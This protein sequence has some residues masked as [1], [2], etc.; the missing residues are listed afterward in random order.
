M[1]KKATL[2]LLSVCFSLISISSFS[3]KCTSTGNGPWIPAPLM[4]SCGHMP[5]CTDSILIR[6]G[7][8]IWLASSIDY[9]APP[10]SCTSPMY[11]TISGTLGFQTGKKLSLPAGSIIIV[12]AGGKISPGAGGGSS[13]LIDIG[14]VDVWTAG[15]GTA[16]GP[17]TISSSSPLPIELISFTIHNDGTNVVINWTTASETNNDYF[18]IEK[19]ED[20]FNFEQVAIVDGAGNST[21]IM[22]YSYKDTNPYN[23][24]SYYRLKQTDFDGNQSFSSIVY[25]NVSDSPTSFDVFPNPSDGTSFNIVIGNDVSGEEILVVVYDL[26][27][28]E[29][30]SK[31]IITEETGDNVYAIDPRNKLVPG[32]YLI[33]ATSKQTIFSKKLIVK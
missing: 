9:T 33:T 25:V 23:G 32:I 10:H 30:Y 13:N 31:I 26:V 5:S 6:A 1:K 29:S 11:I 19:T 28:K 21:T 27:G 16:T 20:G 12:T 3:T 24:N 18:T 15:Y 7:D 8:S 2:L 22:N 4:W 14:G 17:L